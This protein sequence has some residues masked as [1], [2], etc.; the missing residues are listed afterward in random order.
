MPGIPAKTA[1]TAVTKGRI[2]LSGGSEFAGWGI[3]FHC[4]NFN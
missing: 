3:K 1:A 2:L 4:F